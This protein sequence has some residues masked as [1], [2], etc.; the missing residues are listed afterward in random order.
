MKIEAAVVDEVGGRFSVREIALGEPQEH[1]VLVRIVAT[2]ICHSDLAV[3]DGD[4]PLPTPVVLGHEGSG[5]VERT[6]ARVT[7]VQPGDKVVITFASCG[8]CR[9]CAKGH[10]GYCLA[11]AE[12]NLTGTRPD[13]STAY[14]NEHGPLYGHFVGQSSFAT[15]AIAPERS[16]VKVPDDAP[17]EL[18][19]PI[20]CGIQ[21]GAGSVM[22]NLRPEPGSS[23]AV[24]GTGS[25]GLSSVMASVVVGCTP[26]VAVDVHPGRLDLA[27][28]LGATHTIDARAGGVAEQLL[29]L[30]GGIGVDYVLDSTAAKPLIEEVVGA[31]AVRGTMALVGVSPPEVRLELDPMWLVAGRTITGIMVGDPVPELFLPY[32][33]ELHAQGRF[34]FDR[35][36]RRCGGLADINEAVDAIA[37]G[38]VVKAVLTLDERDAR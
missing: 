34:P 3:R 24:L 37:R 33:L 17:L 27:R 30:T 20:G 21:T 25:V 29:E 5:V 16:V 31:L 28:E 26:I 9:M 12:L 13:G 35:L 6:G 32:L 22:N 7:R 38:D 14:S 11:F 15:Y 23:M 36:V 18:L 8:G 19:A 10:P 1:E 4:L 2:G